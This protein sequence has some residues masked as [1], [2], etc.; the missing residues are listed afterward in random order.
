MSARRIAI[1]LSAAAALIVTAPVGFI[2]EADAKGPSRVR[3]SCEADGAGDISLD[4]RYETRKKGSKVRKKFKAEFEADNAAGF[5]VGQVVTV[6][7]DGVNVGTTRL[8]QVA[9][10]DLE[11][12]LEF[13]SKARPGRHHDDNNDEQPFPANFPKVGEGSSVAVSINGSEVLGCILD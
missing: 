10:G 5:T 8:R 6:T 4:S 2:A 3:L 11:G 9:G 7:V 13:D 1:L 12:E